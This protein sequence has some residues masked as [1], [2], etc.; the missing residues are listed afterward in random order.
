MSCLFAKRSM[1]PGLYWI[2]QSMEAT[3]QFREISCECHRNWVSK[4]GTDSQAGVGRERREDRQKG[5]FINMWR[6]FIYFIFVSKCNEFVFALP[7]FSFWHSFC[8][9]TTA[10]FTWNQWKFPKIHKLIFTARYEKGNYLLE[11]ISL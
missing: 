2:T 9:F 8:N 5:P 6:Q 4:A 11:L 3:S 7:F 10:T 1:S